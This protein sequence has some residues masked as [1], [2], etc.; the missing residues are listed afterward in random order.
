MSMR[1]RAIPY[2]RQNITQED[3]DAVVNTLKSD[4]LTQGPKVEEFEIKFAKYVGANYAVAVANGTA[5]LHL[6][7]MALGIKPGQKVISSPITFAATTNAVLY[8]QGEVEFCDIDP[9]TILLN[10]AEVRNKLKK[11]KSG[12]YAGIIPVDFAG[13]PVQMDDFRSLADE[14]GIWLLEDACHAPGGFYLD[15]QGKQQH[16]GNG[17]YA[18]SAIFSFHPV[19]HIACGEGGMITT[20]DE[21]IYQKL[22]SLR[23]HGI[24]KNP[25]ELIENHGG[26]YHEM[27]S[28]G[29]N[30]RLN[31]IV[32]SLGI[33]QLSRSSEGLQKRR[34]IAEYYYKEFK[35]CSKIK[36]INQGVSGHAYHL[37]VIQTSQRKELY[38]YLIERKIFVQVHYIPVHLHPYYQKMGFKKGD[39]PLAEAFYENCLSLP[40]FPSL[41]EE[42]LKFTTS[43]IKAFFNA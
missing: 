12:T 4:F 27:Q 26:W 19:K 34:L 25:A 7:I 33:S 22:L 28:L 32:C 23:S 3:I 10:I 9:E 14:Y 37:F 30:Y 41:T 8:N 35:D 2:G 38:K 40:I 36:M 43:T 15:A 17:V 42:E 39:F 29:Y 5:A 13:T 18:H 31:D 6:S 16:C 24:T 1:N 21:K 20:N 11:S